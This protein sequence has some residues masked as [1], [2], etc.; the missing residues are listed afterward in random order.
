[1]TRKIFDKYQSEL[2][3]DLKYDFEIENLLDYVRSHYRDH[4]N[5]WKELFIFLC[6]MPFTEFQG[7]DENVLYPDILH[8][9]RTSESTENKLIGTFSDIEFE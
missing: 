9:T 6:V 7:D 5:E 1:M 2:S 3:R 8:C 4:P